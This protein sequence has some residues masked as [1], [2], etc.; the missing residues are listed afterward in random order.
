MPVGISP[1]KVA[2]P[3]EAMRVCMPRRC[4]SA[5]RSCLFRLLPCS[6]PVV[7]P[8]AGP[9][10]WRQEAARNQNHTLAQEHSG[11]SPRGGDSTVADSLSETLSPLPL[12]LSSEAAQFSETMKCEVLFR[13][14]DDVFSGDLLEGRPPALE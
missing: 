8:A 11:R 2:L 14:L 5:C 3:G 7:L 6:A 12:S 10:L 9:G 13:Q 4:A 1:G